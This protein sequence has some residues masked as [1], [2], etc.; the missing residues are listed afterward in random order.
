VYGGL[1]FAIVGSLNTNVRV[2]TKPGRL[3]DLLAR[4]WQQ[5]VTVSDPQSLP[6]N[7]FINSLNEMT[8]IQEKRLA[9]L[10]YHVPNAVVLM[11]LAVAMVAVGS[12]GITLG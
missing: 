12:L 9:A 1:V 4:L 5:A 7:R 10:R 2:S 8:K 6:A 3:Q 11:L